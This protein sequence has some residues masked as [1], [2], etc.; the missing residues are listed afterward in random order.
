[1]LFRKSLKAQPLF[2]FSSLTPPLSLFVT[3]GMLAGTPF[4][5]PLSMNFPIVF[6]KLMILSASTAALTA[7]SSSSL[8]VN[9]KNEEVLV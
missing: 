6:L 4:M 3:L 5:S 9:S 7:S 1:M 2:V 8:P